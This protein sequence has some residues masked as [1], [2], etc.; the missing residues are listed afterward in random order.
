M[1]KTFTKLT[2]NINSLIN[3][4]FNKL[5]EDFQKLNTINLYNSQTLQPTIHEA[6]S[7]NIK[8]TNYPFQLIKEFQFIDKYLKSHNFVVS[9]DIS[10]SY[11]RQEVKK[12]L[13]DDTNKKFAIIMGTDYKIFKYSE[14]FDFTISDVTTSYYNNKQNKFREDS[15]LNI[16]FDNLQ[17]PVYSFPLDKTNLL[18]NRY[19]ELIST[20]EYIIRNKQPKSNNYL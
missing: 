15:F 16:K 18:N 17:T 1:N 13:V 20:L 7:K 6:L 8:E 5:K 12:F 4:N 14:L 19:Q 3:E 10:F 11:G 9:K 2:K